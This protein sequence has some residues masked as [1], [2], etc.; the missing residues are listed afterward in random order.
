MRWRSWP[1]WQKQ[2]RLLHCL[3]GCLV[4]ASTIACYLFSIY[5]LI[6]HLRWECSFQRQT[7]L[8]FQ[9]FVELIMVLLIKI[10]RCCKSVTQA[11]GWI[12]KGL[13]TL[14]RSALE[15][16]LEDNSSV[17]GKVL[18]AGPYGL[19]VSGDYQ[20]PLLEK[21]LYAQNLH[22]QV[23]NSYY[24]AHHLWIFTKKCV[25]K[26]VWRGHEVRAQ[27]ALVQRHRM[28]CCSKGPSSLRTRSSQCSIEDLASTWSRRLRRTTK[29]MAINHV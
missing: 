20:W 24:R 11:F 1:D 19:L 2:Q 14:A 5:F 23:L 29:C 27:A 9:E 3:G 26:A 21:A 13:T 17:N 28:F 16:G 25:S 18:T 8:P 7:D 6:L 10:T 15:A 22:L 4:N 12:M